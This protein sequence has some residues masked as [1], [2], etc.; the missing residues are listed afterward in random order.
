MK[1]TWL[2]VIATAMTSVAL[3]AGTA[4]PATAAVG[5]DPTSGPNVTLAAIQQAGAEATDKRIDSLTVA[6]ARVE[7]NESLTDSHRATITSTLQADLDGMRM[8]AAQIAADTTKV[9]AAADYHRIFTDYRVYAVALPQ[10]LYA[11]GADRLT[12][13]AIPRLQSAYERLVTRV[14]DAPTAEQQGLLD[15]MAAGIAT[16]TSGA[17]GLA[18]ASL[19]VT[20]GDW[21]ADHDVMHDI[22]TRLSAAVDG[23]RGAADAGRDLVE[24]LR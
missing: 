23:A 17:D 16:A 24:T 20:P 1:T 19:A 6:L 14:G 18:A 11:A 21:D 3:V 2:A 22:H 13:T 4:L 12:Q 8:L 7:A 5:D 15:A 9:S 10:A